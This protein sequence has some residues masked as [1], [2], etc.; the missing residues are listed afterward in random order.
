M[1]DVAKTNTEL[2][3]IIAFLCA[4]GLSVREQELPENCVLPGISI[5]AG[6]LLVDRKKL[7]YPG[8]LL[9]E[10]GHL[11]VVPGAERALLSVNV[12]DEG[13][14][15]MGAIAWSYA[16]AVAI[17]LPSEVVFHDA[18]Y[19]GGAKHLRENFAAGRYLGVPILQ[20]RG[21][22]DRHISRYPTML[23]WLAD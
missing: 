16:A 1:H 20:W 6:I 18:G 10:A 3:Q 7:L 13:G 12:G 2:D 17:G 4:I 8:D 23:K 14:M 22:T 11:A 21:L 19:K 9:H 15:E 5:D